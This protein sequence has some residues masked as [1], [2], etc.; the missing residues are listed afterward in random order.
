[1]RSLPHTLDLETFRECI[2]FVR[3]LAKVSP[4]SDMVAA[5]ANPG[6]N[7]T[8]DEQLTEWLMKYMATTYHT[9]STCSM[10]PKEKNGVVDPNLVV[11]GTSNIRVCDLSILPLHFASHPQGMQSPRL[12]IARVADT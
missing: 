3:S 12:C 10:L 8:T 6:P 9:A 11:Y 2:K 4:W 5:E 7:C 1:M